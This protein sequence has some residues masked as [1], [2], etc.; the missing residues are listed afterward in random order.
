MLIEGRRL[1]QGGVEVYVDG[2]LLTP[3]ASQK[4]WNH[5]PDGFNFGYSGSGPAQL[6]LALLL[7]AGVDA[8]EA[9]RLHQYF[10]TSFLAAA[11]LERAPLRLDIDVAGWAH[12]RR[13]HRGVTNGPR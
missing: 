5:S 7:H 6:A 1:P 12:A 11:V 10:K 4:V 8:V 13:K 9:I 2:V 3:A